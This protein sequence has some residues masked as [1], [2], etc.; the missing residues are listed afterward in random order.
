MMEILR[1]Y[2]A[3][4]ANLDPVLEALD[5]VLLRPLH[6]L[7]HEVDSDARFLESRTSITKTFFMRQRR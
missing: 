5:E 3:S 2:A 1:E 4:K 6:H 7:R